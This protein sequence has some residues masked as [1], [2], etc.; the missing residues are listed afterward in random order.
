MLI[1]IRCKTCGGVIANKYTK[2]ISLLRNG[3]TP[4]ED[5]LNILNLRRYCCRHAIMCVID[6]NN[7]INYS[8][9]QESIKT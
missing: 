8:S 7:L 6:Y 1:P 5:I 2:Y 4:M 9:Q 3:S